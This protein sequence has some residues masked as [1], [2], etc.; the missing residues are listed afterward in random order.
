MYEE[1]EDLFNP[2]QNDRQARRKRKPKPVHKPKK[3]RSEIIEDIAD[4]TGLEAGFRTTYK[5]GLFEEEWLLSSLRTFYDQHLITDVQAVVKGG[6][7]ASVYR[8]AGHNSTGLT[9]IA[10]KVYR[11]RKFRNL[12]NDKMYRQ[13]REILKD[14]GKAAKET[15]HRL[16]RAIGKKTS[17]G[18]QAAHTSWLMYEYTTLQTLH[19]AGVSVPQPIAAGENAILMGYVGD[20]NNPAPALNEVQLHPD[21][22]RPLFEEI[23]WN[24]ELMLQHDIVHGDLSP[25]NILYWEGEITLI[26]F[27]QVIN[28]HINDEAFFILRRDVVRVCDY[29]V[30]HGLDV[31]GEAIA[32]KLWDAYVHP[33]ANDRQA[34]L[35]RLEAEPEDED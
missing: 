34:D 17:Y 26:D 2:I 19:Q 6:K 8:C 10:A 22:V 4:T 25:Y 33:D 32:Q 20:G 14:N 18:Q 24:I 30:G 12:R 15:D 35:S 7:E 28:P 5:P 21:E 11:P 16:M 31:D 1:Y 3:S 27:P 9:F 13:G 23:L 29:F